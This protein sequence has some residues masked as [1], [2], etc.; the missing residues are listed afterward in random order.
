MSLNLTIPCNADALSVALSLWWFFLFF[1]PVHLL[2][3]PGAPACS[4]IR[5]SP[6]LCHP[7]PPPL[8]HAGCEL[9]PGRELRTHPAS[10]AAPGLPPLAA[11]FS[12]PPFP[13]TRQEIPLPAYLEGKLLAERLNPG[14]RSN[15]TFPEDMQA[16]MGL[17]C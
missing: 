12:P 10:A 16:V 13:G 11:S 14:S 9:S 8:H 3:K 4:K 15:G 1:F 2:N 7:L 5:R 6:V 17:S